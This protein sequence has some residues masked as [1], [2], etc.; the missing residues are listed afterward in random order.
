[1]TDWPALARW[2]PDYLK[3]KIGARL[4][5]FQGGRAGNPSFERDKDTHRREARFDAF[6]DMILKPESVN[7]AYITAYN[8][9]R[10]LE[11]LATLQE[12]LG[13]LDKFLDTGSENPS[14]MM[15]IGPAGTVT[16]LHHDLTNN[17]IAQLVGR[18]AIK[19]LPASE[20]GKLYNDMHVFSEVPDLDDSCLDLSRY[21]RLSELRI[22][23]VILYPGEIIFMPLGWW[24]QVKA[25]DFSVTI[26]YTNFLWPNDAHA[27]YPIT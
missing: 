1:M 27:S 5:E 12:D 7:D 19:L 15:W 2:T 26:T 17:F 25:L 16:S 3:Q 22:Y 21:P 4:I 23:D 20:V 18:K 9:S 14:G 10:N 13:F 8:S 6:M 11:A 24:H